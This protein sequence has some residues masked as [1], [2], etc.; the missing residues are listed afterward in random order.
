LKSFI[1]KNKIKKV[2]VNGTKAEKLFKKYVKLNDLDLK[3]IRL[4]SSSSAN[5]RYTLKQK[6][7]DWKKII[8]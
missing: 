3:C 8:Q 7:K 6:I 2:F 5:T 1:T 4:T